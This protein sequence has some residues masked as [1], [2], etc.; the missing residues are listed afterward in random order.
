[1]SLD[2]P[3]WLMA[4]GLR[5]SS[6]KISQGESEPCLGDTHRC[7]TNPDAVMTADEDRERTICR[8]HWQIPQGGLQFAHECVLRSAVQ[9][10]V[11]G[12]PGH[13]TLAFAR[14]GLQHLDGSARTQPRESPGPAGGDRRLD[15]QD[16]LASGS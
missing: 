2:S 16:A 7:I 15:W 12:H 11:L 14:Y 5:N 6:R 9:R 1:M 10:S 8:E 13:I 4:A 3:Y